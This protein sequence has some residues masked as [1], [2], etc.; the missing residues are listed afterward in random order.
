MNKSFYFFV[1]LLLC[2]GCISLFPPPPPRPQNVPLELTYQKFSDIKTVAWS[3]A[4]EKP[5]TSPSLDS[6]RMIVHLKSPGQISDLQPLEGVEWPDRLPSLVQQKMIS[7]FEYSDKILAVGHTDE[8]FYA[9]YALQIDLKK[10]E[11]DLTTDNHQ[12]CFEISAKLIRQKDRQIIARQTFYQT[13]DTTA[14]SQKDFV[15]AYSRA[16]ENIIHQI[17]AWTLKTGINIPKDEPKS[18]Q[19]SD[20]I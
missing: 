3:L 7:A 13:K 14:S 1:L 11:I 9:D 17:T 16:L 8:D 15:D 19:I 18:S 12:A 4:I 20:Q 10:A 6:K 2:S 5:L